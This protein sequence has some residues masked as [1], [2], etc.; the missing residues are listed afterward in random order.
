[1]ASFSV[2]IVKVVTNG[3]YAYWIFKD[4]TGEKSA[5]NVATISAALDGVKADVAG[6][7]AGETVSSVTMTVT[8]VP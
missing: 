2:K 5:D 1:M 7:L 4:G 8:T 6:L 3:P